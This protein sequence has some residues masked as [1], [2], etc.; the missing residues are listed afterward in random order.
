M[1]K[2]ILFIL[3]GAVIVLILHNYIEDRK[4]ELRDEIQ[5]LQRKILSSQN[6]AS[7]KRALDGEGLKLIRA[8]STTGGL[9]KLQAVVVDMAKASGIELLSIRPS[10]VIKYSYHEGVVLYLEAKGDIENINRFLKKI[11]STEM[12]IF[13]PKLSLNKT[14]TANSE[15]LRLT[16]ELAGLRR[17]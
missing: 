10:P 11:N 16:M 6:S 3:L 14:T 5:M 1:R 17:L 2:R 15:E 13:I 4:L 12:A 9:S 8:T 7:L